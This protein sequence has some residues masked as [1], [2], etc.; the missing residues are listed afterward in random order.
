[1]WAW[2]S[3]GVFVEIEVLVRLGVCEDGSADLCAE[4]DAEESAGDGYEA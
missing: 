1:M 4:D 2:V 3:H